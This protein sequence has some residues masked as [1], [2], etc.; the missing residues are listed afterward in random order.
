M[1][2]KACK[3]HRAE[4]VRERRSAWERAERDQML[5]AWRELSLP[6]ARAHLCGLLLAAREV[7]PELGLVPAWQISIAGA[8]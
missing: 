4:R 1:S 5:A 8:A 6:A 2:S 7:Q 3:A